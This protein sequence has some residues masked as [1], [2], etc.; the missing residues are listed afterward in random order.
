[1][2]YAPR[3]LISLK[4]NRAAARLTAHIAPAMAERAACACGA[5][6]RSVAAMD[7]PLAFAVAAVFSAAIVR[8]YSG[9]GFS[10]LAVTALSL[11]YPPVKIVP[12]I[13]IL[14]IAASLHLL[15]SIWKDIHW[16]SLAPLIL[17]CLI[18]TPFGVFLLASLDAK[19][20]RLAMSAFVLAAVFLLWLGFALKRMPGPLASAAAGAASGLANGA[21]GIGGPPAILFYFSSP[22][23]VI[24]GRASLIAYFLFTDAI[25]LASLAG[26]NLVTMDSLKQAALCLPALFAGVW[27]GSKGFKSSSQESFR[28]IALIVM[29]ALAVLGAAKAVYF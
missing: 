4:V 13:F 3:R 1:M 23:G 26:H 21:F 8:G 6:S 14:E 2:H 28:K 27:L 18:A 15:P 11:I 25:G 5:V 17:G 7:L 12:V 19:A 22:A 9:F 29:A 10:L 20:M 16:K 24:S